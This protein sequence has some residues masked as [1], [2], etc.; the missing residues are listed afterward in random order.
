MTYK[1]EEIRSVNRSY[2]F[3]VHV[4]ARPGADM[5]DEQKEEKYRFKFTLK[6]CIFPLDKQLELHIILCW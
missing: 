1:P 3:V 5:H 4:C 6:K 2:L